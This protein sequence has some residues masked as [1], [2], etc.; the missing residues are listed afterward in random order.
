MKRILTDN[1]ILE[2]KKL[3]KSGDA[4]QTE[5]AREYKVSTMTIWLWLQPN[6]YELLQK[7]KRVKI[8]Y[9]GFLRCEHCTR[10]LR[11]DIPCD[12]RTPKKYFS[13]FEDNFNTY[14]QNISYKR[15][16]KK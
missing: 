13:E 12:C 15:D 14:D 1:D 7:K 2:I 16:S 3:Y 5:L 11:D 9:D 8:N 6:P 4:T 10:I